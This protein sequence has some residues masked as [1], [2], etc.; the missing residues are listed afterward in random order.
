MNTSKRLYPSQ[1]KSIKGAIRIVPSKSVANRALLLQALSDYSFELENLGDSDDVLVMK[2]ALR[3]R[4]KVINIGMAGT[5]MRFLTAGFSIIEGVRILD[6]ADRLRERPIQPLIDALKSMGASIKY[7]EKEGYLPIKIKGGVLNG[8]NVEVDQDYSSQFVSALMLIAPFLPNGLRIRRSEARR[9]ESYINLTKELMNA[10]GFEV[11]IEGPDIHISAQKSKNIS[12]TI[13][14][15]WSSAAY[16]MAFATLIPNTNIVLEGLQVE[17]SQGDKKLLDIFSPLGLNYEWQKDQLI[18]T[19]NKNIEL[20]SQLLCDCSDIPDQAQTI[21]FLGAALGLKTKLTGLETLLHK[22]TNRIE[23]LS[24]ELT[25][26]GLRTNFNDASL[27]INGKVDVK[28]VKIDTYNDHRM[29]MAAS[30]LGAKMS[31]EI[32]SPDVVRKS[33]PKFW[34]DLAKLSSALNLASDRK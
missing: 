31:V 29:A 15:D 10:L 2:N 19:N 22:E 34:A 5:A 24:N 7:L 4:E 33:Y 21:A 20:P 11:K 12:Y 8:S 30:L 6:G 27:S 26:L 17:S 23:A 14:G 16:W 3:S 9:S 32:S 13:E 25:K 1:F 28:E 18:L